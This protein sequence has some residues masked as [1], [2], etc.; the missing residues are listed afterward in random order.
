MPEL[1]WQMVE[2][3]IKRLREVALLKWTYNM[4]LKDPP[5]DDVV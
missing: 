3:G 4:S 1:L 2:E 5:K